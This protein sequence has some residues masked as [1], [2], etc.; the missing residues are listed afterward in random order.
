MLGEEREAISFFFQK[1]S[2]P[3]KR[4]KDAKLNFKDKESLMNKPEL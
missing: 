4:G 1:R 3:K 2:S